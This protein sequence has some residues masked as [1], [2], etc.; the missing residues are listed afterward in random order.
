MSKI[1]NKT[2][3][4]LPLFLTPGLRLQ[5]RIPQGG[6]RCFQMSPCTFPLAMK[7]LVSRT[8]ALA[9]DVWEDPLT[10]ATCCNFALASVSLGLAVTALWAFGLFSTY[11]T[12]LLCLLRASIGETRNKHSYEKPTCCAKKMLVAPEPVC[13][14]SIASMAKVPT[15]CRVPLPLPALLITS[16]IPKCWSKQAEKNLQFTPEPRK[17]QTSIYFQRRRS[18]PLNL[19]LHSAWNNSEFH[20][21][22]DFWGYSSH[23]TMHTVCVCSL[24]TYF[25]KPPVNNLFSPAGAR[26]TD[27]P[28]ALSHFLPCF[29]P[30][31]QGFHHLCRSVLK[32]PW[33]LLGLKLSLLH[34]AFN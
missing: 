24:P 4:S 19:T 13:V 33:L 15:C 30:C 23:T 8:R 9:G 20:S 7:L 27:T 3:F 25:P 2:F 31:S 17:T 29:T 12:L 28:Q 21:Y 26:G 14:H 6:F 11:L 10:A 5:L 32:N 1:E 16:T 34:R 18:W 22:K